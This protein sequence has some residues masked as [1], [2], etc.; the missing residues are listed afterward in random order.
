MERI[1]KQ[2]YEKLFSNNYFWRTYDKKEVDFV[3]ERNG[4]LFGFEFKWGN[5]KGKVQKEWLETC[6]NASFEIINS[7]NFLQWYNKSKIV[8]FLRT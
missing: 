6:S 5:N 8:F 2:H 1:K 7:D 4:K 3:E